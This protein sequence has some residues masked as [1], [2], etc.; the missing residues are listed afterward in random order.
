MKE[1]DQVSVRSAAWS[2]VYQANAARFQ[3]VEF[4]LEVADAVRG[5]VQA[6]FRF[7]AV[8]RD[9]RRFAQRPKQLDDRLAGGKT[10]RLDALIVDDLAIDFLEAQCLRVKSHGGVEIFD[11]DRD[12]VDL[13]YAIASLAR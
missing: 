10:D 12:V 9:R 2:L 7:A 1:G 6:R 5:M 4:C 11:D 8:F 3:L 13:H